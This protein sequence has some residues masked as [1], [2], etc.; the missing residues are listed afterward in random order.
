[1]DFLNIGVDPLRTLS[2]EEL[3]RCANDYQK[4]LRQE[5]MG[6]DSRP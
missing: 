6:G 5:Q 4:A 2:A 1:M 3:R